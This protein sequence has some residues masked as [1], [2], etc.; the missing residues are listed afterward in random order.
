KALA[1]GVSAGDKFTAAGSVTTNDIESATRAE[2][3]GAA[4]VTAA[5]NVRLLATDDSDIF[6]L[7]G[8]ASFSGS[9]AFGGAVALNEI[10]SDDATKGFLRAR[11]TGGTVTAQNGYVELNADSTPGIH[12]LAIGGAG[13]ETV[14]VSGSFTT[15]TISAAVEAGV[16]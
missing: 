4:N 15:N 12:A 11:V 14:A 8:G 9:V 7:A 16:S 3:T 10:G 6:A 13:G 2:I 1:M 5:T